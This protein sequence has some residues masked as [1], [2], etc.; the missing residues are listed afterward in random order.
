[1]LLGGAAATWPLAKHAQQGERTR[2]I[3]ILISTTETDALNQARIA[4]FRTGLKQHGWTEGPERE[5]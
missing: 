4:A 1:M 3:G 2:R 5:A